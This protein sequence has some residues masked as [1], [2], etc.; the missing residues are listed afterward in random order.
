MKLLAPAVLLIAA[1]GLNAQDAKTADLTDN[2][3][4]EIEGYP[5]KAYV[6]IA[7]SKTGVTME[8]GKIKLEGILAGKEIKLSHK[9]TA[10]EVK[11]MT[12]QASGSE[13]GKEADTKALEG[14]EIKL[15]GTVSADFNS[16]EA[17]ITQ[18]LTAAT[19][20]LGD[21]CGNP[22][23]APSELKIHLKREKQ[24]NCIIWMQYGK[25]PGQHNISPSIKQ[26]AE[27]LA[28]GKLRPAILREV[29]ETVEIDQVLVDLKNN[30]Y[31]C[32]SMA[33]MGHGYSLGEN[34]DGSLILPDDK[35]GKPFGGKAN[36]HGE[37]LGDRRD[38]F[39]KIIKA[40]KDVL[41][42]DDPVVTF[43]TC[44]S[45]IENGVAEEVSKQGIHTRGTTGPCDFGFPT[46]VDTS[47]GGPVGLQDFPKK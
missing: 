2:W 7:Q 4:M 47:K 6:A 39:D 5:Q 42:G 26:T 20:C 31:R 15:T 10:D 33:I 27:S 24:V 12:K 28:A 46:P 11:A 14:Q 40:L 25:T 23:V 19:T 8:F 9:L 43:Y 3:L 21:D 16:I 41:A 32:K 22:K 44:G 35:G 29:T 36:G 45:A 13:P 18:N 1:C 38:E 34:A 17:T 37:W 30:G